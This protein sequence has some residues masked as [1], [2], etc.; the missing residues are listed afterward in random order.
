[1]CITMINASEGKWV[2]QG[3][4]RVYYVTSW[5]CSSWLEGRRQLGIAGGGVFT[6]LV[7]HNLISR[8]F[9]VYRHNYSSIGPWECY[10]VHDG[11]RSCTRR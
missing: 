8:S 4:K 6:L 3:E 11:R 9:D 2:C 5:E 1:M 7:I 10:C